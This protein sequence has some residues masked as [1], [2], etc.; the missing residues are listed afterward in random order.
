[1]TR[2]DSSSVEQITN[3]PKF[4]FEMFQAAKQA[5]PTN[6]PHGRVEVAEI[7]SNRKSFDCRKVAV[8]FCPNDSPI[9]GI[10]ECGGL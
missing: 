4:L 1:M 5:N 6:L 10:P 7:Y 3:P 9:S 8:I 2:L